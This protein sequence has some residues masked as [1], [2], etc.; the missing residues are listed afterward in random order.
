[1]RVDVATLTSINRGAGGGTGET[2]AVEVGFGGWL[3]VL[4]GR[5]V[6]DG[7]S[8]EQAMV[9]NR[10]SITTA[11]K[12]SGVLSIRTAS[13]KPW[14]PSGRLTGGVAEVDKDQVRSY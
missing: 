6:G 10:H 11:R 14:P 5:V 4:A 7:F 8:P 12:P 13:Y 3:L 1:M 9:P 2:V